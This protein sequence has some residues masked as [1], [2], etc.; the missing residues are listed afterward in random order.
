[1]PRQSTKPSHNWN[2]DKIVGVD[3]KWLPKSKPFSQGNQIAQIETIVTGP[4]DTRQIAAMGV[5]LEIL[6]QWTAADGIVTVLNGNGDGWK[7]I[8]CAIDYRAWSARFL[9]VLSKRDG[10]PRVERKKLAG[11]LAFAMACGDLAMARWASDVLRSSI[12]DPSLLNHDW[13][14][15]TSFL[16]QLHAIRDSLSVD[17]SKLA[18]LG[19]FQPI[20]DHWHSGEGFEDALLACSEYH[21]IESSFG[22]DYPSSDFTFSPYCEIPFEILAVKK[23]QSQAGNLV[24]EIDH[25]L[26]K[27]ALCNLPDSL[28]R[29]VTDELIE[30]FSTWAIREIA[31]L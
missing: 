26:M 8:R 2:I 17:V 12:G 11:P 22:R 16:V 10:K 27:T 30:K 25:P 20:I 18:P 7:S 4:P 21:C 15:F 14:P 24:S 31:D 13:T 6:G 5:C 29:P 9:M 23:L 1:M 28:Q 3:K 19:P